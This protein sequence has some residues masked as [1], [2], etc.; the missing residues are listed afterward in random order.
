MVWGEKKGIKIDSESQ[1]TQQN[2]VKKKHVLVYVFENWQYA[3]GNPRS[4]V[5]HTI[6]T[7]SWQNMC[8]HKWTYG[9]L[10]EKAGKAQTG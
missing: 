10:W 1:H 3:I 6:S 9:H 8:K 7:A 5:I 2:M 4:L